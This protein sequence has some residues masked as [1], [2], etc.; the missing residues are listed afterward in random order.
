MLSSTAEEVVS[1]RDPQLAFLIRFDFKSATKR[2]WTGF[3]KLRTLDGAEW[4]GLGEA[5]SIDGLS[6][7]TDGAATAGT[8]GLSGVSPEIFAAAVAEDDD[9]FMQR[10]VTVYLQVFQ[11]RALYGDPCPVAL[12]IMTSMEIDQ[13]ASTRSIKVNHES[14]YI[15]RNNPADGW[16]SDRDQQSRYPG[17]RF[18]ERV[19]MNVAKIDNWPTF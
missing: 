15:V 1:S 10:P 2:I 4:D 11:N 5:V 19:Y 17:D 12:R 3:G 13:D 16:Y 6:S 18:C 7:A 9:E 8:L 14:P